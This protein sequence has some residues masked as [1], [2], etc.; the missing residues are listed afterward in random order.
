MDCCCLRGVSSTG[1]RFNAG[2]LGPTSVQVKETCAYGEYVESLG[3]D[4]D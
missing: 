3:I 4:C 2:I 1:R